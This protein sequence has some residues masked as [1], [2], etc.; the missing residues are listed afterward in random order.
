MSGASRPASATA[1]LAVGRLADDLHLGLSLEDLAGPLAND[2]V[3]LGQK[4][5]QDSHTL[6]TAGS[7]LAA[8]PARSEANPSI[9]CGNPQR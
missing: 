2:G 6:G 4:D 9:D 7:S 5:A 8:T 1:C 3:I